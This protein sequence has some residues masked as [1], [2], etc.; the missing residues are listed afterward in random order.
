MSKTPLIVPALAVAVV[1][2]FVSACKE[3]NDE[4]IPYRPVYIEFMNQGI[5]DTYGVNGMG[6][7]RRFILDERQPAGFPY[8]STSA[9]GYGGVLLIYGIDAFTNEDGPLAYDLACPV[10]KLPD[11]R[12][13]VDNMTYDAVCP[14]CHSHYNVLER[15]GAPVS[16]PAKDH[17]Y[18]LRRYDCVRAANTGYLIRNQYN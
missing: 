7:S 12:V 10:E 5:W 16:G 17:G 1:T 13:V 6:M 8:N 4:R 18:G 2:L 15:G 3:V 9:T 14:D 11:V